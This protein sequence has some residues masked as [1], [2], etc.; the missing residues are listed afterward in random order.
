[1]KWCSQACAGLQK[2]IK[3]FYQIAMKTIIKK[4]TWRDLTSK[5]NILA[6]TRGSHFSKHKFLL[7]QQ[8]VK[9]CE[10]DT[11]IKLKRSET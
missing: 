6:N 9:Q 1:M 3:I 2:Q 8:T 11:F 4:A 10:W 7:W 5:R